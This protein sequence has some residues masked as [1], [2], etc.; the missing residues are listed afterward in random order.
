MY[1][2]CFSVIT[3]GIFQPTNPYRYQFV[4]EVKMDILSTKEINHCEAL[5]I[6]AVSIST[7]FSIDIFIRN[8]NI[9]SEEQK[10]KNCLK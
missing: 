2:C 5:G 4:G 10:T 7:A 3:S 8:E 1:L 9:I 6:L